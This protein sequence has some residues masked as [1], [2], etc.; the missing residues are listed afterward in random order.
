MAPTATSRF[1][2]A[3]G[4][5]ITTAS[6]RGEGRE[7]TLIRPFASRRIQA[8][9]GMKK[10]GYNM[11]T[12]NVLCGGAPEVM[13]ADILARQLATAGF[14]VLVDPR[15]A[16]P[17]TLV[18]SGTVNQTFL[19]PKQDFFSVTFETDIELELTAQTGT[20]V[21]AQR[22]FYVK[23]AEAT[24]MAPTEDMQR[25]FDSSVRQLVTG[26]VGA[27]ANLADRVPAA[28]VAP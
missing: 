18:L 4:S 6:H 3:A 14:R 28:T 19:E 7:V 26:V 27:V 2:T 12:A 1:Q 8:R 17:S 22:R 13:L 25:S 16:G 23:G 21:F 5:D 20:G 15:Q 9:C 10:N 24:M 11:D